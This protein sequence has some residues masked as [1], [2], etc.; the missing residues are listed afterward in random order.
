MNKKR[1][2]RSLGFI[3]LALAGWVCFGAMARA[4]IDVGT[5]RIER[6]GFDPRFTSTS[7]GFMVQLSDIGTNPQFA[8]VRQ[9][10]LST[11][12]GN[13]GVATLLTA[14]SLGQTVWVRIAGTGA[15]GS[16]IT[17]LFVNKPTT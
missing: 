2:S 17:I 13:T 12:L 1:I 3:A 5:A 9:F 7:S 4:D 11:Q 8:G 14:Y 6:L 16:L 10:Y 15:S